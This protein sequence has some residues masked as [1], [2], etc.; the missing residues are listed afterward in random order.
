MWTFCLRM[1]AIH[2]GNGFTNFIQIS[3]DRH[4]SRHV[5]DIIINY[6]HQVIFI[7]NV[8]IYV[9]REYIVLR[10]ENIGLITRN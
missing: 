3:W 2:L 10:N 1:T 4:F 7:K 5:D 6:I 8:I 9:F